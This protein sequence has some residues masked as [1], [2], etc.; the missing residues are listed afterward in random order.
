MSDLM[1]DLIQN[2]IRE[3]LE[4]G[5]SRYGRGLLNSKNDGLDFRQELIEEL[6]DAVIYAAADVVR[7][8]SQVT[9]KMNITDE[10]T[11]KINLKVNHE[12]DRDGNDAVLAEIV[13]Q[14]NKS[15]DYD[16][17]PSKSTTVLLLCMFGLSSVIQTSV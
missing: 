7:K 3:R 6:L 12:L 8:T 13:R 15:Y 17:H 11:V 5:W 16:E 14:L 1:S 2:L 4:I 10:G 9:M